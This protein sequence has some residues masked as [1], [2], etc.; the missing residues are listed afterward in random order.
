MQRPPDALPDRLD[1]VG[2]LPR[3]QFGNLPPQNIRNCAAIAADGI[4]YPTPSAPSESP[5]RAVISSKALMSPCVL[6][7]S[8]TGSGTR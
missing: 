8:V 6:S 7:L 5:T 2:L 1:I 3:D 4:V